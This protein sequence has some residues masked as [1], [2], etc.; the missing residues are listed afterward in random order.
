MKK[1]VEL[2]TICISSNNYRHP[3]PKTFNQL[4]YTSLHYTYRHL[5]SSHLNFTQLHFTTWRNNKDV[6]ILRA[7]YMMENITLCC[8]ANYMK[9]EIKPNDQPTDRA[10]HQR[11]TDRHTDSPTHQPINCRFVTVDTRAGQLYRREG[12]AISLFKINL[13]KPR[14]KYE[15]MSHLPVH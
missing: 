15:C 4:H 12:I 11:Q 2:H 10:T 8:I 3:V 14:H 5:T 9:L 7:V 6:L 1:A 13:L